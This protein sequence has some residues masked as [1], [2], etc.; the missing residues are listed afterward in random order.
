ML[1]LNLLDLTLP[2]PIENLALDEALLEE[3]EECDSPPILR[4]WES[5]RHFVVL[6]RSSRPDEDVHVD[7][8]RQDSIPIL[9]RASGGGTVLQGPGCLSYAIV[10]PI[11]L[12]DDLRDIRLTNRFILRRIAHALARWQP[13]VDVKGISDLAVMGRKIAGSAQRRK[14]NALLFHGTIL[15]GMNAGMIS[16]YL[17]QPK[18]QPEY[19]ADRP[20]RKFLTTLDAPLEEMKQAIAN[21]WQ[22][23]GKMNSWPESRM[24][25]AI[26]TVVERT[27]FHEAECET[28]VSNL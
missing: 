15:Y 20:H 22:A 12:H 17:K 8:C 26:R 28:V 14:R 6:G 21:A 2:S 5:D 1:S 19:R 25:N 24:K 13:A 16:R 23:H 3:I 18:R 11:R 27:A 9:R 4:L 7:K 10:L